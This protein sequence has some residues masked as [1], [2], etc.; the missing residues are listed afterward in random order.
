MS[1]NIWT[2]DSG[3]PGLRK[4]SF[5]L[6]GTSAT[7][8]S[9]WQQ[10]PAWVYAN[11]ESTT[12]AWETSLLCTSRPRNC[13]HHAMDG[14]SNT[15]W[16]S[17][18]PEPAWIAFDFQSPRFVL[19]VIILSFESR[20]PSADLQYSGDGVSRLTIEAFSV[21]HNHREVHA[22]RVARYWRLDNI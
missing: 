3:Y 13:A 17:A 20:F 11:S 21:T 6:Q 15:V 10:D 12:V 4:V 14:Y 16:H 22:G 18:H 5:W 19:A 8:Q 9:K 7:P 2:T 1:D